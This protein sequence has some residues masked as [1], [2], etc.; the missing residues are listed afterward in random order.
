MKCW[1]STICLPRL[2]KYSCSIITVDANH[3]V[4]EIHPRMP[5]IL[6]ADLVKVWLDKS[7]DD[8]DYLREQIKPAPVERLHKRQLWPGGV[9]QAELFG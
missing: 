9:G 6:P 8:S 1:A 4:G 5:F 2:K 7:T 3:M